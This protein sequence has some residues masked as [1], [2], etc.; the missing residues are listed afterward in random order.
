[1]EKI[2]FIVAGSQVPVLFSLG[3]I[4]QLQELQIYLLS[5]KDESYANNLK[6]KLDNKQPLTPE[7]Q[8][9]VTVIQLVSMIHHSARDSNMIEYRDIES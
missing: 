9:I 3:M 2:P 1:M 7:E 5:G 4:N 6:Q 8:A